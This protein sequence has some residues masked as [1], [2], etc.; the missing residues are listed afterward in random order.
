MCNC[1]AENV[2][3]TGNGNITGAQTAADEKSAVIQRNLETAIQ[4]STET[5][6]GVESEKNNPEAT[7][8][9]VEYGSGIKYND[10]LTLELSGEQM[11][12]VKDAFDKA[13]RESG[14]KDR[15]L[16]LEFIARAFLSAGSIPEAQSLP[17][18]W[19]FMRT[20]QQALHCSPPYCAPGS[21]R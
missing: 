9:G 5:T 17:T 7:V 18:R 14:L 20:R 11:A 6:D 4:V 10:R 13:R 19:C 12:L 1:Q 8:Q 16:L 21:R 2:T 3:E 15:A